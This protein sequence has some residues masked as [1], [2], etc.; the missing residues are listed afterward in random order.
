MLLTE[1]PIVLKQNDDI[2]KDISIKK[3]NHSEHENACQNVNNNI[4]NPIG[5]DKKEE[6]KGE[7]G[8][9]KDDISLNIKGNNKLMSPIIPTKDDKSDISNNM[10]NNCISIFNQRNDMN[11]KEIR[12]EKFPSFISFKKQKYF[13]NIIKNY[14]VKNSFINLIKICLQMNDSDFKENDNNEKIMKLIR[15]KYGL[16][17]FL[18]LIIKAQRELQNLYFEN[19]NKNRLRSSKVSPIR[20]VVSKPPSIA[21]YDVRDINKELEMMNV[22]ITNNNNINT[23]T[24]TKSKE[25][26][27]INFEELNKEIND[28]LIGKMNSTSNKSEKENTINTSSDKNE[29]STSS[30]KNDEKSSNKSDA[31]KQNKYDNGVKISSNISVVNRNSNDKNDITTTISTSNN[32]KFYSPLSNSNNNNN[33]INININTMNLG[34]SVHLHKDEENKIYK[35]YLHH[36]MNEGIA[37]FYCSDKR[38]SGSA[39]YSIESKR[40]EISTNHSIPYEKHSY[41]VSPFPNDQK[42]FKEFQR[43]SQREAQLF[44]QDN[45]RSNIFWYS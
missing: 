9:Q 10:S 13:K 35:Y 15:E 45:G 42:L 26:P 22:T 38:C 12:K 41:I 29:I 27:K 44:K 25:K 36:H 28:I 23:T 32:N 14:I 1:D 8:N 4:M 3:H 33:S 34:L 20:S 5:E 16:E 37:V 7:D 31:N 6:E 39:R 17:S 21:N 19:K 40:F 2:V 30:N 24:T 18:C 11:K 43:R